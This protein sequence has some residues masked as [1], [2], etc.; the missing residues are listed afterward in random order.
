MKIKV[1]GCR[2]SLP[3][4]GESMLKYGGN[5][6]CLEIRPDCGHILI[7]DAGSGIRKLGKEI[8]EDTSITDICL[9]LTHS[10]WDHLMGFPFF[11]PAY[12]SRYN[13][14]VCGGTGAQGLVKKYLARQMESPYFP[15]GFD[16]LKAKFNFQCGNHG[17]TGTCPLGIIPIPLSHP[18]GAYGFKFVFNGKAFVFLTDNELGMQHEGG[19]SFDDYVEASKNADL[20]FHDA[21]YTHEEYQKTKGWGHS[22]YEEVIELAIKAKVKKLGFFHHDPDRTDK[23]LDEI[24]QKLKAAMKK[25]KNR[26]DFFAVREGSEFEI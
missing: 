26:L 16:V 3:T 24:M 5:T 13:I 18:N 22:T 9:L 23:E 10:H 2:G 20:L 11:V 6:T 21:Q 17:L 25:S 19:L 8:L 7:V 12:F 1:W 4:P 15:V 14:N